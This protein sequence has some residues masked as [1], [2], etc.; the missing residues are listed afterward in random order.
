MLASA[1]KGRELVLISILLLLLASI[2]HLFITN[3]QLL[4]SA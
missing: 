1:I 4:R 3:L 2:V